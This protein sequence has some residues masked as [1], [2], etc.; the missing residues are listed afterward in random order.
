MPGARI[1]FRHIK[2]LSP[3]LNYRSADAPV[4]GNGFH[5]F[6]FDR[7]DE[8]ATEN[9][10]ACPT[11]LRPRDESIRPGTDP[12]IATHFAKKPLVARYPWWSIRAEKQLEMSQ[13]LLAG[14]DERGC[15]GNP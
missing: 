7:P 9:D 6:G 2:R 14:H 13:V 8:V 12:E 11:A 15:I 4:V 1:L 5:G 3:F 10:G